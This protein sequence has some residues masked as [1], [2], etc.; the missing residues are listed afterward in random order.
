MKK[1]YRV[2]TLCLVGALLLGALISCRGGEE[3]SEG[4]PGEHID[5]AASVTLDMSSET[6]KQEVTV[7]AYVD[8]DT[9]HFHIPESVIEGG[10]LKARYLAVNTP[11]STGK[12]EEWGKAASN[13]TKEKLQSAASIL[14]ESD[15]SKWNLDSTGGRYLVWV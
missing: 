6:V 7:K 11:E 15:D 4:G 5:Y 2:F 10:V 8:G 3:Q 12:I 9:T 14:I 13:Y 1:F